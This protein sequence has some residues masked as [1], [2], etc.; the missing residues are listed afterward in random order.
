MFAAR[1]T[2]PRS[3]NL[4]VVAAAQPN[5][6]SPLL[7]SD[8]VPQLAVQPAGLDV[9]TAQRKAEFP[10]AFFTAAELITFRFFLKEFYNCT[11]SYNKR[12]LNVK[13]RVRH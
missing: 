2:Y 6:L 10:E 11:D 8:T 4:L 13:K 1:N 3:R 5:S 12:V 7:Q 9:K